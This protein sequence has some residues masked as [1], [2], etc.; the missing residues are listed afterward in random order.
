MM[1]LKRL[2]HTERKLLKNAETAND[3]QGTTESYLQDGFIRK[4]PEN[5]WEQTPG[6]FQLRGRANSKTRIVF[7]ASG[8]HHEFNSP[9]TFCQDQSF[10]KFW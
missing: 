4:V 5:E 9:I 2:E 6:R 1:V 10:R 8:K 3:C 7:K